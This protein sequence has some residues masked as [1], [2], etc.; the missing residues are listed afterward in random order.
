[1]L[2][3]LILPT[4]NGSTKRPYKVMY[5]NATCNSTYHKG[6]YRSL[7]HL[8]TISLSIFWPAKTT[9]SGHR[10]Y[11]NETLHFTLSNTLNPMSNVYTQWEFLQ[12][13]TILI[14]RN[15]CINGSYIQYFLIYK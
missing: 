2:L 7:V 4:S 10:M 8:L 13:V 11:E 15:R 6:R 3:L 1:M 12:K 14:H 5:T 9:Y